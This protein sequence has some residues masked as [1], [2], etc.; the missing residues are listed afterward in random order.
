MVPLRYIQLLVE[1]DFPE[2]I[3]DWSKHFNNVEE[4][5]KKYEH[6]LWRKAQ[7]CEF[8]HDDIDVFVFDAFF[9]ALDK[10]EPM[11]I[12]VYDMA[13]W[14][15]VTVLSEQSLQTGQVVTFP[16]FTDGKWVTKK[17]TFAL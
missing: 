4:Y 8:G 10:G 17:N 16:D 1:E 6:P 14:M 3:W 12:D 13:T 2:E 9:E 5:Y 7:Q 15:S 11:P